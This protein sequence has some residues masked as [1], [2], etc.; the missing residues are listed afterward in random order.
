V[1]AAALLVAYAIA[2]VA[3]ASGIGDNV[4][5]LPRDLSSGA[6]LAAVLAPVAAAL[7]P[8]RW[9]RAA[10]ATGRGVAAR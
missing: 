1:V 3:H 5:W 9:W 10:Y 7:A 8:R 4:L 2:V 6:A